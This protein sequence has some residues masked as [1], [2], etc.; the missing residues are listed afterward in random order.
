MVFVIWAFFAAIAWIFFAANELVELL[1]TMGEVLGLS[2]MILGLTLLAWG[3]ST[4]GMNGINGYVCV[5][6]YVYVCMCVCVYVCMC[7]C[8]YVCMCVCVYVLICRFTFVPFICCCMC[9]AFAL[10]EYDNEKI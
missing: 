7:V 10:F 1:K 6:V 2:N 5:C 8:V 4:A 3:G 9:D